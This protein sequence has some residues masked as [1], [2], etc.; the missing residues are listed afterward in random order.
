MEGAGSK[1][2]R[3]AFFVVIKALKISMPPYVTE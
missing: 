3:L 1:S 2:D